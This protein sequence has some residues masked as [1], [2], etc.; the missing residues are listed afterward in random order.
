[1]LI[2]LMG[3]VLLIGGIA[4]LIRYTGLF[5]RS[6]N[7]R[8]R[9]RGERMLSPWILIGLAILIIAG[10]I[11]GLNNL[12]SYVLPLAALYFIISAARARPSR[13]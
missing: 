7:I 4:R 13:K 11:S 3:V 12:S 8:A 9:A 10:G 5:G 2:I 1:M 6:E